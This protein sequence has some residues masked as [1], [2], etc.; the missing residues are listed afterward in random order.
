[1][2]RPWI[3]KQKLEQKQDSR[4]SNYLINK[5]SD[6]SIVTEEDKQQTFHVIG[7]FLYSLISSV[8]MC[9]GVSTIK[10]R[11]NFRLIVAA[12]GIHVDFAMMKFLTIP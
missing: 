1:M 3:N 6:F 10:E 2:S 5:S 8:K 9:L 12:S 4:I 7:F 11:V